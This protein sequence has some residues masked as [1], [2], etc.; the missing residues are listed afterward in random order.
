MFSTGGGALGGISA[1]Q[2][3]IPELSL[4]DH[5]EVADERDGGASMSSSSEVLN[6][7]SPMSL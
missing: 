7:S 3:A 6:L 2:A 4:P 1:A 5:L